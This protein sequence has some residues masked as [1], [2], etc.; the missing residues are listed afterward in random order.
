MTKQQIEQALEF[1]RNSG[2]PRDAIA[3]IVADTAEVLE[4]LEAEV[5]QDSR[6]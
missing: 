5:E 4:D 3:N 6:I 1:L 2:L